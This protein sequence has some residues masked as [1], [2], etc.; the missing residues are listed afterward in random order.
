MSKQEDALKAYYEK[1]LIHKEEFF[2]MPYEYL[3]ADEVDVFRN[4]FGFKMFNL[5]YRISLFVEEIA[6]ILFN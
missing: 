2:R 4:S 1:Y 3:Y 5:R 6:E